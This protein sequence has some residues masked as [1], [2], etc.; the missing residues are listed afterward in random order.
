[1]IDQLIQS[2]QQH[3]APQ[4]E[5]MGV[6]PEQLNGVFGVVQESVTDGLQK[7]AFSGGMDSVL[8]LFNGKGGN[9]HSNSIVSSISENVVQ[10]LVDKV[11][12]DPSIAGKVSSMII[13]FVMEKFSGPDSGSSSSSTDLMSLL[14]FRNGGDVSSTLSNILGDKDKG[15]DLLGKLGNL[16]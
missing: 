5:K 7:E 10:S 2:A 15:D 14:G 6:E 1:M 9:L 4:L 12:L 11:G 3:L 16:F 8:E 13:P